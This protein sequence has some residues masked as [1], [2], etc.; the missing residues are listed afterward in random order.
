ML[1]NLRRSLSAPALLLSF[2]I[3]WWLPW[4]AAVTWT[5]FLLVVT[6]LP[7]L[8]P[9]IA[10][11]IPRQRGY[12]LR[13][14]ARNL[15]R[16]SLLAIAQILFNLTFM[17]RLAFLALDAIARTLFRLFI[18]R[19]HLLEWVT[20]AQST[21]SRRRGWGAVALQLAGSIGFVL[22]ASVI[23]G[24]HTLANL[25]LGIPFFALWAFSPYWRAG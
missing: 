22:V 13:S 20:F 4:N 23:I 15:A 21:Y 17:A 16:D 24:A 9:I 2:L 6:C 18:S 7:S 5:V 8:L 14:H 12:S 3:G 10:G 1:D 25:N 19:R 11:V